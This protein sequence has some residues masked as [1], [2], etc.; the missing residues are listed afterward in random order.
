MA[1]TNKQRLTMMPKYCM[2]K[3]TKKH[4]R[5]VDAFCVA[6][7]QM[8]SHEEQSLK[9]SEKKRKVQKTNIAVNI[10]LLRYKDTTSEYLHGFFTL[11]GTIVLRT[12][13]QSFGQG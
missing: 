5:Q 9:T 6:T 12:V 8:E 11:I 2:E 4:D 7:P 1:K 13:S 10:S 3:E